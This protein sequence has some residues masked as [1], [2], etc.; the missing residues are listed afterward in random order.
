MYYRRGGGAARPEIGQERKDLWE[1]QCRKGM[2]GA[3]STKPNHI[4]QR[5]AVNDTEGMATK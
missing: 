2:R 1:R 4:I 5:D 3:P